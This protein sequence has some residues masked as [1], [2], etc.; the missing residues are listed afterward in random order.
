MGV[1]LLGYEV[2]KSSTEER[3]RH[4]RER[5][6][7]E[8]SPAP[9]IDGPDCRPC[10]HKVDKTEPERGE[11]SLQ[12]SGTCL[13]ENRRAVESDDVDTAHLLGKH[14]REGGSSGT[15][16]TRDRE[17]LD[18]T[19]DVVAAADDIC[20]LLNLGVDIVQIPRSLQ[21]C[22]TEPTKGLEGFGIAALL[23]IPSW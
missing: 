14:D 12:I 4:L 15:S 13:H 19:C 3:P 18:E 21:R 20:L 16:N 2:G 22:V 6:D 7:E 11:Q 8:V 23:D 5:E 9:S 10:E 17:E 1:A